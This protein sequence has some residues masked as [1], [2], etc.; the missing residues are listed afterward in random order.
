MIHS[1]SESSFD[2]FIGY[3]SDNCS[4][5]YI[6]ES[7]EHTAALWLFTLLLVTMVLGEKRPNSNQCDGHNLMSIA[8][9]CHTIDPLSL[10]QVCGNSLSASWV[11]KAPTEPGFEWQQW[12]II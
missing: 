7:L 4:K 6:F 9:G 11:Y 1:E 10:K 2:T 8:L 5:A 3:S 12:S